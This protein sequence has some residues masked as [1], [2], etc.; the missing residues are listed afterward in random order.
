VGAYVNRCPNLS[1]HLRWNKLQE[2]SGQAG[3]PL[4]IE[5]TPCRRYRPDARISLEPPQR[6]DSV[7]SPSHQTGT[8]PLSR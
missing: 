2:G 7:Q 8:V 5:N 6:L 1:A 4:R 3:P